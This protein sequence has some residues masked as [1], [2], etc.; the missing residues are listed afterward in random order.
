MADSNTSTAPSTQG[1]KWG[2]AES[3]ALANSLAPKYRGAVVEVCTFPTPFIA[4]R[5]LL[6]LHTGLAAAPGVLSSSRCAAVVG[7]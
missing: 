3:T 4:F 2:S 7:T 6:T 1:I 5:S